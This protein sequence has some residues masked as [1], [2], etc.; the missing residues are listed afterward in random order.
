MVNRVCSLRPCVE[1]EL[2]RHL[3]AASIW[4]HYIYMHSSSCHSCNS[5]ALMRQ[6]SSR[7]S[8]RITVQPLQSSI[9]AVN[10]TTVRKCYD[11]LPGLGD[12][13]CR[14]RRHRQPSDN[15]RMA[16]PGFAHV[17][18]TLIVVCWKESVSVE[19]DHAIGHRVYHTYINISL[20]WK[21]RIDEEEVSD[22]NPSSSFEEGTL[23]KVI[24]NYVTPLFSS[25]R[26]TIDFCYSDEW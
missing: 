5:C 14:L 16:I 7:C 22:A 9:R 19:D 18:Y 25:H 26:W 24:L 11:A 3:S 12:C 6:C 20:K 2:T 8:L 21:Y 13:R 1:V 10:M 15:L 17:N 23:S 4:C